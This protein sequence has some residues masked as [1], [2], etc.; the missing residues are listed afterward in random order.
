MVGCIC[1]VLCIS[2]SISLMGVRRYR[3]EEMYVYRCN[4]VLRVVDGGEATMLFEPIV[5]C[6]A[7]AM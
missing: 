6:G 5:G 1:I 3:Y 4:T 2:F 7:F